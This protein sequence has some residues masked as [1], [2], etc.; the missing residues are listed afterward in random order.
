MIVLDPGHKYFVPN[1]ESSGGQ[2]IRFIK[3]SSGMIHYDREHPG[4]NTQEV[5]RVL[6]DRT[7]YLHGVG[8]CDETA[9]AIHWLKMALYEYEARAW[10]RKQQ[11][12]NKQ[13][14]PQ[15]ETDRVTV[16]RDVYRDV[17]FTPENILDLPVGPDG[18]VIVEGES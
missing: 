12:L 5:I 2:S 17:P 7:E 1:L 13:E 3:R 10:R 18:H 6:I 16:W 4:T 11:K 14:E 8:P 9:N 15:A